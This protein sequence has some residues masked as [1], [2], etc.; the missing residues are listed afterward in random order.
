[1][2]SKR[3]STQKKLKTFLVAHHRIND[4]SYQLTCNPAEV[5]IQPLPSAEAG[6]RFSDP[7]GM[8]GW[9][10]LCYEKVDR[11]GI[12]LVTC[13]S[14]VQRPTMAP[15]SN[16]CFYQMAFKRNWFKCY[17]PFDIIR[18]CR[19]KYIYCSILS[20]YFAPGRGTKYCHQHVCLSRILHD[21]ISR[22]F[23]DVLL[24]AIV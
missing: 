3:F 21:Q 10:D 8:Q 2:A 20:S 14:Q 13:Q 9:V 22:N 4:N 6:T 19:N 12:E 11:L 23:L 7:I 18:T 15:P 16:V 5:R 1:M 24:V 17:R